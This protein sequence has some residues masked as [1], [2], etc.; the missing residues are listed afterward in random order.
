MM[1]C[2]MPSLV[3]LLF[4]TNGY[5]RKYCGESHLDEATGKAIHMAFIS[6]LQS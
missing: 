6:S 3:E 1:L 2:K 4:R 5:V